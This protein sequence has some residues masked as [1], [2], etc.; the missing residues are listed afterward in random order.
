MIYP[1]VFTV[2]VC[3][4]L[5]NSVL[6]IITEYAAYYLLVYF[7]DIIL[8]LTQMSA[9][10]NTVIER[11]GSVVSIFTTYA[12]LMRFVYLPGGRLWFSS[13]SSGKC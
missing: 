3:R 8:P 1:P 5:G 7:R 12:R 11:C 9:E 10:F 4:F 13:V 2:R 6:L